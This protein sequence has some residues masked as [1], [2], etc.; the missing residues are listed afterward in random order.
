MQTRSGNWYIIKNN[1]NNYNK[2]QYNYLDNL[3]NKCGGFYLIMLDEL[4]SIYYNEF[5]YN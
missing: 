2:Y 3:S 1:G 5:I 4:I